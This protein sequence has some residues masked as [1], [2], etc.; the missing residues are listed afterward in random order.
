MKDLLTPIMFTLVGLIIVFTP[1]RILV[2]YDGGTGGGI[3]RKASDAQSGLRMAN[4]F[5]KI[6]GS[7]FILLGIIIYATGAY[8]HF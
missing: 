3:Y 4:I 8:K 6:F 5:Y 2:K 1:A 7:I